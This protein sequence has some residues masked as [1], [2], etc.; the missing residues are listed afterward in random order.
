MWSRVKKLPLLILILIGLIVGYETVGALGESPSI[1]QTVPTRTPT[2]GP[3]ETPSPPAPTPEPPADQPPPPTAEGEP[4]TAVPTAIPTIQPAP[5]SHSCPESPSVLAQDTVSVHSGPGSEFDIVGEL[6]S[7][8][9]RPLLARSESDDW[10]LILF[11]PDAYGWVAG[12]RVIV[13]GCVDEVPITVVE[14][15]QGTGLAPSDTAPDTE[16]QSSGAVLTLPSAT[17][18]EEPAETAA[19]AG[20]DAPSGQP[21]PSTLAAADGHSDE[22]LQANGTT[23]GG[24]YT[25]LLVSGIVL[26]L[27]GAALTWFSRRQNRER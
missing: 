6:R 25:W 15:L 14:S 23:G 13:S 22:A 12:R 2:P 16:D 4:P 18:D 3:T 1:S 10:W 9:S 27:G 21:S 19:G 20:S 24:P 26:I 11:E 5:T 7:G 17:G 8:E